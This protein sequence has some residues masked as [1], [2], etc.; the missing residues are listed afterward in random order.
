MGALDRVEPDGERL[1]QRAERGIERLGERDRL[2]LVD[3]DVLGEPAGAAADADHVGLLAVRGF[4]GEARQAVTAADERERGHVPTDAPRRIGVGAGGDDL[5]A[6]LVAHH[7]AGRHRGAQLEVGAADAAGRHLEHELA[8]SRRRIGDV[9]DL[10]LVVV[11]Q[12]GSTH[13]ASLT[14]ASATR[15]GPSTP[16]VNS[17]LYSYKIFWSTGPM[18]ARTQP[19]V[20]GEPLVAV[21]PLSTTQAATR[22]RLLDAARELASEGGYDAVGIAPHSRSAPV[23]QRRRRTSTSPHGTRS[24]SSCSRTSPR[25]PPRSSPPD[26]ADGATRWSARSRPFGVWRRVSRPSRTCS[27]P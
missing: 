16:A 5:A 26:P 17:T 22:R 8:G 6:E 21:R 15:R 7:Q 19:W 27:S 10:E 9:G 4:A 23:C 25:A 24:S 12:H 1:D 3:A 20:L 2:P 14:L 18:N 13:G 11:V